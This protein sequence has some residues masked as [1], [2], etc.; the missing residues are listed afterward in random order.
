[1]RDPELPNGYQ[2]ADFE[3]RAFENIGAGLRAMKKDGLCPHGWRHV[4]PITGVATCKDCGKIAPVAE[5]D[6][7]YHNL[8]AEYC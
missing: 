8:I 2:D 7:E 4:D 6:E 1:M 5:L 3:M